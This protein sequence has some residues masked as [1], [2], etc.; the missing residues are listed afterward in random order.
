MTS[1]KPDIHWQA[2]GPDGIGHAFATT[3][4]GSVPLCG[5]GPLY[6]HERY[7]WPAIAKCI[8]CLEHEKHDRKV[9][10]L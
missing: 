6:T 1:A 2:P 9:G 10:H 7:A 8:G 5:A 4:P 3:R